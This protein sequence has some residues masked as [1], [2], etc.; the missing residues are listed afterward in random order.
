MSKRIEIKVI[1][2]ECSHQFDYTL[3]RSIW[4]EYP[5][6][7]E[8][9]MSD[10]INVATCPSCNKSTKI[11][12]PFIYT[13]AKQFF[14][15]W[16]EPEYD[17]Q[18]DKDSIGYAKLLGEDNYL[19]KAP[20]IKDWNEFKETILKFENGILKGSIGS[21]SEEMRGQVADMF[22]KVQSQ[23]KNGCLGILILLI[24]CISLFVT[25]V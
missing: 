16:W 18:I 12:F 20:R 1:C 3:Y 6:N 23:N 13:N 4:G 15:V 2:P 21:K 10:K 5:E 19:A 9:V 17:S 22:K 14:A 7:R 11:P 24:I 8:L 25:K